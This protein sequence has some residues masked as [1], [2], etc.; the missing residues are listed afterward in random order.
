[1]RA[2]A[3]FGNFDLRIREP[4][5]QRAFRLA[6][7]A[8]PLCNALFCRRSPR[9]R[10]ATRFSVGEACEPA[11]QYAFLPAKLANPLC[12]ALFGQRSPR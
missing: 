5:L 11:L 1:M 3:C 8:N 10:F 2:D 4:A 6:N 7:P 12:N 9:T